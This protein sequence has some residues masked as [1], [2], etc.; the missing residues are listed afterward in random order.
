MTY[1]EIMK[2]IT[3]GLSGDSERDIQYLKDQM[4]KYKEHELATEIIRACGRIFYELIPDDKKEELSHVM[5]ND[6]SGIHAVLDEVRF[7][8]FKKDYS[9]ALELMKDLVEKTERNPMYKNDSVTEYF[10]F[11]TLN[12]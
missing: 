6:M 12:I 3:S 9:K 11:S 10:N 7:N 5:D 4:E 8:I 2:E 1:D